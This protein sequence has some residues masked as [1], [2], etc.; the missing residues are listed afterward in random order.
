MYPPYSDQPSQPSY[1]SQSQI[2]AYQST[3]NPYYG[4]SN[5]YAYDNHQSSEYSYNPNQ[6]TTEDSY[7]EYNPSIPGLQGKYKESGVLRYNPNISSDDLSHQ[8]IQ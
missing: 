2:D 7:S 4:Y 5:D 6:T 8:K 3:S 1:P